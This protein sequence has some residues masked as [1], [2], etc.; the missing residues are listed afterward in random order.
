V[1]VQAQCAYKYFDYAALFANF[2]LINANN[3]Q[4]KISVGFCLFVISVLAQSAAAQ[5][6]VMVESRYVIDM[7]TAGMLHRG[8][9]AFDSWIYRDGGMLL[10]LN[11][12]VFPRLMFGI[13]YGANNVIGVGSMTGQNLPG[14]NIKYRVIE[15]SFFLP[16]FVLGFDSQGKEGYVESAGRYVIKPPGLYIAASKNYSFLGDLSFH[17]CVNYSSEDA[18]SKS[19]DLSIGLEKSLGEDLAFVS[20]YDFGLNDRDATAGFGG[21]HGYLNAGLRFMPGGGF[22]VE[23]DDKNLLGNEQGLPAGDRTFYVG[24]VQNF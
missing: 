8:Q 23:L 10:G 20:S 12:G 14:V 6:D 18:D 1:P 17:G 9:V 5:N 3:L 4:M 16:A 2:H 24:Y 21:E 13:S 7:P 19:P 22:V 15:E 11:V